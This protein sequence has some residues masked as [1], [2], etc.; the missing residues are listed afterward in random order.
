[1]ISIIE[2]EVYGSVAEHNFQVQADGSQIAIGS[3]SVDSEWTRVDFPREFMD[4][5]IVVNAFLQTYEGQQFSHIRVKDV[6]SLG[7]SARIEEITGT[8]S[9]FHALGKITLSQRSYFL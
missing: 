8:D 4:D 1:M 6:D 2:V 5:N 9:T 3:V 7:F